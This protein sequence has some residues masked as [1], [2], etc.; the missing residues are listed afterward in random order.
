MVYYGTQG[1]Y[2]M[3]L[4][5]GEPTPFVLTAP[6]AQADLQGTC[7]NQTQT[8]HQPAGRCCFPAWNAPSSPSATH[9]PRAPQT[10]RWPFLLKETFLDCLSHKDARLLQLSRCLRVHAIHFGRTAPTLS[11]CLRRAGPLAALSIYY[12]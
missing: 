6:N 5:S 2:S 4:T 1:S 12:C 9:V 8:T 10:W 3:G 7:L 11:G